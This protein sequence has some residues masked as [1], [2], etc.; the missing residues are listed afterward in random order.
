LFQPPRI[1]LSLVGIDYQEKLLTRQHSTA[2]IPLQLNKT[3]KKMHAFIG[4]ATKQPSKSKISL[5][6]QH[7]A[8]E[9]H[10]FLSSF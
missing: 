6:A 4:R 5:T 3:A 2:Y 1:Y 10:I 9:M 7:E 8:K